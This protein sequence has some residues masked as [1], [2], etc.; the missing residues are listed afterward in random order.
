MPRDPPLDLPVPIALAEPGHHPAFRR[1]PPPAPGPSRRGTGAA[2]IGDR[3]GSGVG[4]GSG[5]GEKEC[6]RRGRG[7]VRK[8]ARAGDWVRGTGSEL[9]AAV[10]LGGIPAW[11]RAPR[12]H[13]RSLRCVGPGRRRSLRASAGLGRGEAAGRCHGA[14]AGQGHE[15]PRSLL[16]VAPPTRSRSRSAARP[17]RRSR[18]RAPWGRARRRRWR[19]WW[20]SGCG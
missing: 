6:W 3:A 18:S 4:I 19:R 2:L 13:P 8:F 17:A 15:S 11:W 9:E 20:R 5:I 12:R 10:G 7:D 14:C 1:H 16:L